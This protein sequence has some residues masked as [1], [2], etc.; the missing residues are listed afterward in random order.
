MRSY[1]PEND[2]LDVFASEYMS[3][4][5]IMQTHK[6]SRDVLTLQHRSRY[7]YL[8]ITLTENIS[9]GIFASRKVCL[10]LIGNSM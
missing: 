5:C 9:F 2:C 1:L 10:I 3:N 8:S 4:E 7:E 6:M